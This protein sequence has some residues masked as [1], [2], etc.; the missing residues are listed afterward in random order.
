MTIITNFRALQPGVSGERLIH[1]CRVALA[2]KSSLRPR[3]MP[4]VSRRT[5]FN[6]WFR[7]RHSAKSAMLQH[8]RA[9]MNRVE[10]LL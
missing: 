3:E 6:K 10:G 7:R 1:P 2:Q 5:D 4:P 8:Q 9:R